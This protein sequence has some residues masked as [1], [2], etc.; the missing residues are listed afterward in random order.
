MRKLKK[1]LALALGLV[2]SLS[3]CACKDSLKDNSEIS[4]TE[5]GKKASIKLEE[6]AVESD[7]PKEKGETIYVY[8]WNQELGERLIYFKEKYPQYADRVEFVN[9]GLEDDNDKYK[10]AIETLLQAGQDGTDKYPSVFAAIS[11]SELEYVQSDYTVS[12]DTLA[13]GKNDMKNM[14]S[15]MLDYATFNGNV[16]ALAWQADPGC[17]LYRTDIAETVLE[18]SKPQLVQEMLSDW[19]KFLE[20][21]D[22]M[23]TAGYKVLSGSDDIK[24]AMLAQKATPWVTDE[25]L[26]IDPV[27]KEYLETAKMLYDGDY[28]NKTRREDSDWLAGF[29][30]NVFGWFV[31]PEYI[32][33]GIPAKEHM[34][35]FAV[36]Q[37]PAVYH[38]GGTY[39]NVAVE[40]PDMSLAALVLKTLCCDEEVM[41]EISQEMGDFVNNKTVM[42]RLSDEGKTSVEILGGQNPVPVWMETAERLDLNN[43]SAYDERIN[44]FLDKASTDYNEGL[45]KTADEAIELI[46]KLVAEAYNYIILE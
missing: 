31:T 21:A 12:M 6:D 28:T 43:V 25:T 9:L 7:M 19:D 42:E 23:K 45:L 5:E 15:Y 18:T 13:I 30:D 33:E 41:T 32:C 40:C 14:Y 29:D 38:Q 26:T 1:V 2:M 3:I 17:F 46:R 34:G 22:K 4:D 8:S 11:D 35:E 44:A 10:T 24:Y 27:I 20:L 16:K 37:G 36:C 39:L